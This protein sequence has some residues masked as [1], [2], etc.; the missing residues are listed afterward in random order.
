[1]TDYVEPRMGYSHTCPHC[2][3]LT[4]PQY[5]N[6]TQIGDV[7]FQYFTCQNFE[8]RGV[9]IWKGLPPASDLPGTGLSNPELIYPPAW[10]EGPEPNEDLP[11]N[12]L[13]DYEEARLVGSMSPR[14][15][16]A[17]L[18]LAL[19]KLCSHLG[20]DANTLDDQ[21]EKLI[22]QHRLPEGLQKSLTAVRVIGNEAVH[23]GVLDLRDDWAIVE[24]LFMLINII[25]HRLITEPRE[26]EEA[27]ELVPDSKK[28]PIVSHDP[29]D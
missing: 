22:E 5:A 20:A 29:P 15:S 11:E 28:K 24:R 4:A 16:A 23:P 18:R 27:Y 12:I 17:L 13:A 25:A 9:T 1:M 2:G 8:C 26:I 14:G 6:L 10:K 21:I 3:V 19:Q 7:A